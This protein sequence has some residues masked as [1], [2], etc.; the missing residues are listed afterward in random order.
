MLQKQ[1]ILT[2]EIERLEAEDI[3]AALRA[4][5]GHGRDRLPGSDPIT[6]GYRQRALSIY[7]SANPTHPRSTRMAWARLL[8]LG[9]R[10]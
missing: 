8:A 7:L 3:R 1:R 10:G 9:V 6:R 4:G 2:A 5:H